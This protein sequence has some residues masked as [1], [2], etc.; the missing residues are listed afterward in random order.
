[1]GIGLRAGCARIRRIDPEIERKE[2]SMKTIGYQNRDTVNEAQVVLLK[3]LPH[4]EA[5]IMDAKGKFEIWGMND[6]YA[7]YVLEI[8]GVGYEFIRS[9]DSANA[10]NYLK[11]RK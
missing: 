1:M 5:L 4:D 9:V 10:Y 8:D 6:G 3:H 7:G 11:G 2:T